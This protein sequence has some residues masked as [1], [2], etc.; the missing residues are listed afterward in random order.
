MFFRLWITPVGVRE[1][2]RI[3]PRLWGSWGKWLA[4]GTARRCEKQG[5]WELGSSGGMERPGDQV[6]CIVLYWKWIRTWG[7]GGREEESYP[8]HLK[9]RVQQ[10]SFNLGGSFLFCVSHLT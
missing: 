4:M 2:C 10:P 3:V 7:T 8:A 9:D 1:E 6:L 5:L